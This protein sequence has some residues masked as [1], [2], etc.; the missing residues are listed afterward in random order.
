MQQGM[1]QDLLK[2]HKFYD[3]GMLGSVLIVAW[4]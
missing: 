2:R 4:G 3:M 1:C